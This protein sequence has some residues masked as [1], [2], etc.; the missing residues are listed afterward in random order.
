MNSLMQWLGEPFVNPEQLFAWGVPPV[1]PAIPSRLQVVAAL[2]AMDV[3][4]YGIMMGGGPYG[5][6]GLEH[7]E[8]Q[9]WWELRAFINGWLEGTNF[10][11][12]DAFVA[13][14]G[15]EYERVLRHSEDEGRARAAGE[16]P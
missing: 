12:Q 9:V 2:K 3:G 1:L 13:A 5:R 6:S 10:A 7:Q 8:A 11:E 4:G 15:R 16:K 14:I